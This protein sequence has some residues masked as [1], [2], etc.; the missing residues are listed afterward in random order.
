MRV[1]LFL[2]PV[3]TLTVML[4]RMSPS[5]LPMSIVPYVGTNSNMKYRAYIDPH[6]NTAKSVA[7]GSE[8]G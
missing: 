2:L 5:A 6:A 4:V 3:D 8:R 7:S 1:I